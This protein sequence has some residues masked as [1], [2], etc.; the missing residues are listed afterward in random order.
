MLLS[1]IKR[2]E[3]KI[4]I[5]FDKDLLTVEQNNYLTEIVN[6]YIVYYLNCWPRNP[7]NNSEFKNCLFGATGI[8]KK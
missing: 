8:V 5:R 1:Y 2:S 3:Y 7:N 6:V 4:G